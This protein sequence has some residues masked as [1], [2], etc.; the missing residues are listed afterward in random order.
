MPPYLP[1][2]STNVVLRGRLKFDHIKRKALLDFFLQCSIRHA[3]V[4]VVFLFI[5]PNYEGF[6]RIYPPINPA[7][8]SCVRLRRCLIVA[9]SDGSLRFVLRNTFFPVFWEQITVSSSFRS[10]SS[11]SVFSHLVI[12]CI[13][14]LM[15]SLSDL[16]KSSFTFFS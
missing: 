13:N 10:I 14:F 12:F 11:K 5:V 3:L 16:Y 2:C 7:N 6:V 4:H 9:T 1:H 15:I 8:A